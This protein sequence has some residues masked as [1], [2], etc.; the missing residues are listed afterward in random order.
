MKLSVR[1][2]SVSPSLESGV[3]ACVACVLACGGA[4]PPGAANAGAGRDST[5]RPVV[6]EITVV[7]AD[8]Q[9]QMA[10]G[11]Q[12]DRAQQKSDVSPP[13]L[14]EYLRGHPELLYTSDH[15][16]IPI[17]DPKLEKR[18]RK[19]EAADPMV[20]IEAGAQVFRSPIR[21]STFHPSW[22]F[23]LQVAIESHKDATIRLQVVDYDGPGRYDSIGAT[24]LLVPDLLARSVHELPRFGAV[25]KLILQVRPLPASR[26]DSAPISTRLA[27]SGR[28]VWTDTDIHVVAGQTVHITAADEVCMNAAKLQSCAGPEGWRQPS[29]D[30]NQ[31]GFAFLGH[32]ALVGALGDTRFP[33]GRDLRF[34]APATGVLRL[35]INDVDVDNNKGSYAVQ[36]VVQPV[37]PAR[38]DRP[39]DDIPPR[40]QR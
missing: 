22:N 11:Q 1:L 20:L 40:R 13:A 17:D 33:V 26:S 38:G 37:A 6:V 19:S 2:P 5:H 39:L 34:V 27:V 30:Y 29:E 25:D 4:S 32:G 18:A 35:G 24:V 7:S 16:G 21:T 28:A 15:L 3:L 8:I 36:V 12:W 10:N 9:G 14:Q 31:P 23:V